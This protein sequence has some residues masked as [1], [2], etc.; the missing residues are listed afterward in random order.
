MSVTPQTTSPSY[1][2]VVDT[3][4]R[5]YRVGESDRSI[6]GR[7]RAWMVWLPW[8]AMMGV[9]VYEYGYSS[10]EAT[11]EHAHG[12]TLTEA[13]WIASIWAVFQAGVAFPAGRLRETGKLSAKTGMLLGAVLSGLGFLS[14]SHVSN[15]VVVILGYS[16]LGGATRTRL[17]DL[18][19]HGRQVVS[20][21]QG[22]ADGL[23]QRRIRLRH[24]AVDLRLQLLVPRR[25]LPVGPRPDRPGHGPPRR[26]LRLLLPRPAQELVA[27]RRGP[28]QPGRRRGR[29]ACGAQ[30][31]QEPMR[32]RGSSP[33]CRPSGPDSCR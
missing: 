26:R 7:P 20:G 8:I 15:P 32:P 19:Q 1:R 29:R 27:A 24:T 18:Y 2:E 12:W 3:N 10:A 14:I 23:C 33:R 25:Q 30:T 21:Q 22:R 28:A 17:R 16:V 31:A 6:L 9:S 13:F 5:V 11:L 4:G